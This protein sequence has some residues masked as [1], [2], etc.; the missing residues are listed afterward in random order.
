M[1]DEIFRDNNNKKHGIVAK[2]LSSFSST[3]LKMEKNNKKEKTT[4]FKEVITF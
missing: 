3:H 4:I 1:I 2:Y